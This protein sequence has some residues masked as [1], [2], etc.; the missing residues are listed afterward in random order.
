MIFVRCLALSRL[1][2]LRDVLDE[3]NGAGGQNVSR[4]SWSSARHA[5]ALEDV[6]RTQATSTTVSD[7]VV[8]VLVVA[9]LARLPPCFADRHYAAVP[10]GADAEVFEEGPRQRKERS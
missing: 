4:S 1:A 7:R 6:M 8:W 3:S 2:Q 10:A 9:T 5:L